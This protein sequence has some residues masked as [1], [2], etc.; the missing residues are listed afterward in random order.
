[1][2]DGGGGVCWLEKFDQ[3]RC[4]C[5]WQNAT[6]CGSSR[7]AK[8]HNQ[9]S[10][11]AVVMKAPHPLLAEFPKLASGDTRKKDSDWQKGIV[12]VNCPGEM[13]TF[14]FVGVIF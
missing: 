13:S 7:S 2:F 4:Y 8:L 14:S 1:M 9:L 11:E 6:S 5:Y 3:P 10:G 12:E